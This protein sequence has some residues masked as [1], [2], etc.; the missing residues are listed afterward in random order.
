MSNNL[1]PEQVNSLQPPEHSLRALVA[2]LIAIGVHPSRA[3]FSQWMDI[4]RPERIRLYALLLYGLVVFNGLLSSVVPAV[5]G[6]SSLPATN[7]NGA[8]MLPG[9]LIVAVFVSPFAVLLGIA[10]I[11]SIVAALMPATQGTLNH[12]AYLL[13]RPFLLARLTAATVIILLD[14]LT[15]PLQLPIVTQHLSLNAWQPLVA[16]A[17]AIYELILLTNALAAVSTRSRW[18]LFAIIVFGELT[19]YLLGSVF[20]V[21]VLRAFGIHTS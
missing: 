9:K 12:R 5:F 18:L 2:A 20:P 6:L 10:V 11:I 1:V 15:L 8:S 16:L 14:V 13:L 4:V 19:G 7:G 17:A 21:A 3:V